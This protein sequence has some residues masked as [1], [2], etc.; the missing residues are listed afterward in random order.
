[1]NPTVSMYRPEASDML[2][3]S[4]CRQSRIYEQVQDL[5]CNLGTGFL[6]EHGGGLRR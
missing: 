6:H 3:A 1:M 2:L 5:L 4:S